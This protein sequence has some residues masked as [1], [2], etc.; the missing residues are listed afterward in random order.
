MRSLL[1]Y[2][3]VNDILYAVGM[4]R[5]MI[6]QVNNIR[7]TNRN[8]KAGSVARAAWEEVK[9]LDSTIWAT[10]V[11]SVPITGSSSDQPSEP[12]LKQATNGDTWGGMCYL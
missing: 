6:I 10:E 8:L 1:G 9:G 11:P 12:L 7:S 2:D 3:T 5:S 4:K